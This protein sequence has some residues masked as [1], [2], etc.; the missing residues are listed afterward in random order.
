M[1]QQGKLGPG[2]NGQ[3]GQLG[4]PRAQQ[5]TDPLGRPLRGREYGDDAT[6]KLPGEIDVMPQYFQLRSRL[7]AVAE[8]ADDKRLIAIIQRSC[9][10]SPLTASQMDGVF[11]S[12]RWSAK[13][14]APQDYR[15]CAREAA[16]NMF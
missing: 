14:H 15:D 2:P 10:D 11:G 16:P 12:D 3:P 9:S 8:H 7:E 4:R 6:V 13:L 5:E 1:Q